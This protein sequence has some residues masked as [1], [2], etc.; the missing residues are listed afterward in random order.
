MDEE[1]I[2]NLIDLELVNLNKLIYSMKGDY[3]VGDPQMYYYKMRQRLEMLGVT[4]DWCRII[5]SRLDLGDDEDEVVNDFVN[6]IKTKY[7]DVSLMWFYRHLEVDNR[8]VMDKIFRR[9]REQLL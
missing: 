2:I 1:M 4:S 3:E 7:G 9:A 6:F 5:Q 8:S